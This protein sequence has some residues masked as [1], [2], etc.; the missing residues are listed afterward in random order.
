MRRLL[1]GGL[2]V[3]LVGAVG[4]AALTL[5]VAAGAPGD[6]GDSDIATGL[7]AFLIVLSGFSWSIL[8]SLDWWMTLGVLGLALVLTERRAAARRGAPR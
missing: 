8:L 1:L 4:T 7:Q 3:L 2:R 5:W 6:P